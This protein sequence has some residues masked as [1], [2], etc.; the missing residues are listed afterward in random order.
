MTE[1]L[2]FQLIGYFVGG[3]AV[4]AAIKADL[5]RAVLLAEQAAMN[6][7]KAHGKIDLHIND[8]LR[9]AGDHGH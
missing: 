4:Y 1:E 3:A 9:R 6:A 8:H 7:E 5:T 2:L